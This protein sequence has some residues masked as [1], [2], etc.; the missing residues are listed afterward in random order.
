MTTPQTIMPLEETERYLSQWK[1]KMEGFFTFLN[2]PILSNRTP[3]NDTEK[4]LREQYASICSALHHLEAGKQNAKRLA[5]A[6]T[7]SAPAKYLAWANAGGVN[8]CT[9]GYSEG[10]PCPKCDLAFARSLLSTTPTEES[11][12]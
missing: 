1:E 7:L 9:H 6:V 4:T 8:E 2:L 11:Q 3:E 10:I 5:T 12:G